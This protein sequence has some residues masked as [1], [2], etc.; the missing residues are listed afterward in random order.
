MNDREQ[1]VVDF[2]H[3]SAEHAA[4]PVASFRRAR[5]RCPVAWSENH[6][7]FWVLSGY[8][9]VCSAAK[10]A[11]VYSS[12]YQEGVGHIINIPARDDG[13][14]MPPLELDPPAFAPYRQLF[15]PYL[16]AAAV[17]HMAAGIQFWCDYFLDA[18]IETG[19]ME[20][21]AD[22]ATPVPSTVTIDWL[23]LPPADWNA[24]AE[25]FHLRIKSYPGSADARRAETLSVAVRARVDEAL[26]RRREHSEADILSVLAQGEANGAAIPHDLALGTAMLVIS[27]G[28]NTTAVLAAHTLCY[29]DRH[30]D[31]HEQLLVDDRLMR[32]TTEEMLR[33]SCPILAIGRRA[34]DDTELGGQQI[35]AGDNVMLGWVAGNHDAE[36]FDAP[37]EIQLDRWPNPHLAFGLGPH[38]CIG[39][40]L[41]RAMFSTMI[42]TLLRRVPD[43]RVTSAVPLDARPIDNAFKRVDIEFTPGPRVLS[44]PEL[45]RQFQSAVLEVASCA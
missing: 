2:D 17:R 16:T 37:D 24:Y 1:T 27:G 7:G 40:N 38:R 29:L 39:S 13:L 36:R 20:L 4:D 34:A 12:A 44:T 35:R 43:Y 18:V 11:S 28:V 9:E 8:H 42:R 30:R 32:T 14:V 22:Y 6:G 5:E 25:A 41:A 23:G 15:H 45:T 26:R 19:Q 10:D 21:I 31:V 33:H 3:H